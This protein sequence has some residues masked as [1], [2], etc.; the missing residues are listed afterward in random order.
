MQFVTMAS[1]EV[2]LLCSSEDLTLGRSLN[3]HESLLGLQNG[4]VV[5][6]VS[7]TD[8]N[9]YADLVLRATAS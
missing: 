9:K 5:Q 4:V 2:L 1:S 7:I 6:R 8:Q 3:I